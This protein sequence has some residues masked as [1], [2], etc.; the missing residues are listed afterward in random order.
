MVI[1]LLE[2]KV[3]GMIYHAKA[4]TIDGRHKKDEGCV[5]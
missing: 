4:N 5:K 2:G 3:K 1:F